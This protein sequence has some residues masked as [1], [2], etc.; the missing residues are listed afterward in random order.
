MGI[1]YF[2]SGFAAKYGLRNALI[3]SE[4]CMAVQYNGE[5]ASG[6]DLGRRFPYLSKEQVREALAAL[7]AAKAIAGKRIPGEFTREIRY[8]P[9]GD[10][11]AR[12]LQD[13]I[14]DRIPSAARFQARK[15]GPA[16]A[17]K[18]RK[19]GGR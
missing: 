8:L 1:D 14:E 5:G 4:I 13:I 2:S 10:I 3:L 16:E 9:T 18:G 11:A 6:P 7:K 19:K 17:A 15:A 12:Y